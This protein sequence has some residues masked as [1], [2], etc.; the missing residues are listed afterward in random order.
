MTDRQV[1]PHITGLLTNLLNEN[2]NHTKNKS[3]IYVLKPVQP[4][5]TLTFFSSES[6]AAQ[7]VY[8]LKRLF[9]TYQFK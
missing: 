8:L 1:L 7:W 2:K 5:K 4:I 9:F 6:T 3:L